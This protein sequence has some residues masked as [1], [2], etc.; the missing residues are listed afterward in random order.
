M[1]R[2]CLDQLLLGILDVAGVEN[3]RLA[4]EVV[5]QALAEAASGAQQLVG[6]LALTTVDGADRGG[7]GPDQLAGSGERPFTRGVLRF[8]LP[9]G[10]DL[11]L[12][13]HVRAPARSR[14]DRL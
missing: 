3:V 2:C 14:I 5:G 7:A 12:I 13:Q 1:D 8:E 4:L 10:P 6:V 9:A 11:D